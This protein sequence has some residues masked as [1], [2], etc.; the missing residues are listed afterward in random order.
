MSGGLLG[1]KDSCDW[2]REEVRAGVSWG[3]QQWNYCRCDPCLRSQ[4]RTRRALSADRGVLIDLEVNSTRG[5][6]D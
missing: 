2:K 6:A 4:E 5:L 3:G 1:R